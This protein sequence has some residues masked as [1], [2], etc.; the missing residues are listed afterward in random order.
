MSAKSE[1]KGT[2][3]L[4]SVGRLREGVSRHL[5]L[6]RAPADS[7]LQAPPLEAV[8]EEEVLLVEAVI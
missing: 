6:A 4:P 7:E 5:V 2:D 1:R 3:W 8:D